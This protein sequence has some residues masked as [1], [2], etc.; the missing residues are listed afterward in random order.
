MADRDAAAGTRTE[1]IVRPAPH[2]WL[3]YAFGGGLPTRNRTWVLHDTT[4]GT[5]ALRHAARALVQMAVPMGL[6]LVLAP[7]PL[8]IRS[9]SVLCGLAAGLVLSIAFRS[10]AT[11]SR[12]VQAGYPAGT[13]TARRDYVALV[14]QQRKVARR[15]RA[16]RPPQQGVS[17]L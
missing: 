3:I 5:W 6:V 14:R 16:G 15:R 4:T 13:G 8:W 7:A 9:V 10:R 1:P 2:R 11:E 17:A 12:V